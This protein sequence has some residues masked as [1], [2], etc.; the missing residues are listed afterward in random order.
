[1][2]TAG[3]RIYRYLSG[4]KDAADKE[5]KAPLL[6]QGIQRWESDKYKLKDLI[7]QLTAADGKK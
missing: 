4:E 2:Q 3:E 1:M 6:M 5:E 7:H